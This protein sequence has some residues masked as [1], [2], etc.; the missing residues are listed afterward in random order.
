MSS[1]LERCNVDHSH[2][3]NTYSF[4]WVASLLTTY[5]HPLG[6]NHG[7]MRLMHSKQE[8]S[9]C[10]KLVPDSHRAT[11]TSLE[12]R[13]FCGA[14]GDSL[15]LLMITIECAKCS[16]LLACSSL[17]SAI[18]TALKASCTKT[19]K[20]TSIAFSEILLVYSSTSCLLCAYFT[21]RFRFRFSSG[22]VCL[23]VFISSTMRFS[24]YKLLVRPGTTSPSP[25]VG[26]CKFP[27]PSKFQVP[28][29]TC[30]FR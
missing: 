12:Y 16:S 8:S 23:F 26:V 27:T 14:K 5:Q 6:S 7:V 1:C 28:T 29:F 2:I 25:E 11:E 19:N 4:R 3:E 22:L 18:F 9:C 10:S 30:L 24:R 13:V 15:D 17:F 20:Q 21:A